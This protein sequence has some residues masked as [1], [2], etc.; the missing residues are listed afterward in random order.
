MADNKNKIDR[1]HDEMPRYFRTR[2]NP[3][4]KALVETLGESDQKLADLVEEVRKQFFVKT[5]SRPYIDRLGANVSR[6]TFLVKV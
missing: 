2:S 6:I 5:A 3:N 4:W 1:I